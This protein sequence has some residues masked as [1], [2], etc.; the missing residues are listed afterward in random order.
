MTRYSRSSTI[1]KPAASWAWA[2]STIN[3]GEIAPSM[4]SRVALCAGGVT[5]IIPMMRTG[6]TTFQG[7]GV[8][9]RGPRYR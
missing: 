2:K 1:S 8:H 5:P 9:P 3:D 7:V 4:T 6:M